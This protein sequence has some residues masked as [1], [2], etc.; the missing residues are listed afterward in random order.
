MNR[1]KG[2]TCYLC[3]PMDRVKDGGVG[4][5]NAV[6]GQHQSAGHA[7]VHHEDRTLAET[8]DNILTPAVDGF[9]LPALEVGRKIPRRLTEDVLVQHL[10]TFNRLAGEYAK[11][12]SDNGFDLR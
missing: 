3:G 4:W 12:V 11:K 7:K 6:S 9:E 1:L 10:E 2:M 5:R 8:G